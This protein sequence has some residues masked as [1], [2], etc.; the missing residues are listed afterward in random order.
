MPRL[1]LGLDSSTQSISAAVIDL[2]AG[3][4]VHEVSLNF[5]RVLPR[6]GTSDGVLR[7]EDP[8]VIHAPPLMWTEALDLLFERMREEGV[9]MR[10]I[11]AISGSGQQHG[12][13]YLAKGADATLARLDASRPLVAQLAGIFTRAT[14][15][16][17]MDSSTT[18]DCREITGTLG[19]ADAVAEATGSA[20]C[21]RFT[22]PQVRKFHRTEPAA[23]E[24]TGHIALVSSFMCSVLAGRI[25]PIDPGDGAGMNLMDIRTRQW[26]AAAV[27]A[28]A[29]GLAAKLP[30]L[31][32]SGTVV[33]PASPYFVERH[34]LSRDAKC[35]IWSGD[36]PCSVVGLGLVQPGR[37]AISMGT[38]YTYFGTMS[39]CRVDPRGE[40]HVFGSPAGGYMALNCFKNGGLARARVRDRYGLDWPGFQRAMSEAPPGNRGKLM[41]PWFDTEIVPKV[42]TPG[43]HRRG[44]TED[45]ASGA[46]RALVEAQMMAMRLHGDWM[47]IRPEVIHATGGASE[48]R[49]VLQV[50]ADVF[51]CPAQ[52][53]AVTKS[54]AL[55]AALI[56]AQA[57]HEAT[58]RPHDWPAMV[59]PFT[60]CDAHRQVFPNPASVEVYRKLL[61]EYA[62]FESETLR[63]LGAG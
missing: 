21:E 32:P 27:D 63:N 47:Q 59:A 54:A 4:V 15:P 42:L 25:A 30:R 7:G 46:C 13:V 53:F 17:W 41:L 31:A 10:N 18:Q 26:H 40:G 58:G 9:P 6:Y 24:A 2:D 48:D 50:M 49:A 34:G 12:S 29:P 16:V 3:R 22:G 38:S 35:V 19:G 60:G 44:L 57:W 51:G 56:A 8:T 14:S 55:G 61:P 52:P 28:T 45:D 43:V 62:A 23:Y 39:D 36:N 5:D 11:V 1:F 37:V 20:A 33:G